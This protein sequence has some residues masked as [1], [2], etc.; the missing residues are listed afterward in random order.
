VAPTPLRAY[1]AEEMLKGNKLEHELVEEAAKVA[2]EEAR[3]ISDVRASAEYRK[4]IVK[5]LTR[6]AINQIAAG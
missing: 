1:K 4:E 5:V 6:R 2:S 3:P